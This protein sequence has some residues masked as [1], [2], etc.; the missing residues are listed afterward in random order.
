MSPID[1]PEIEE[2]RVTK[3]IEEKGQRILKMRV[4]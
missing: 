1:S 3:V 2:V 4:E